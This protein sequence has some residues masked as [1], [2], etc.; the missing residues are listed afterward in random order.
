MKRLILYQAEGTIMAAAIDIALE[1]GRTEVSSK[2]QAPCRGLGPVAWALSWAG[3]MAGRYHNVQYS[4]PPQLTEGV[5]Q[6]RAQALLKVGKLGG[7]ELLEMQVL[8]MATTHL[9]HYS[10][11][12]WSLS[13]LL[14]AAEK[15][16]C[17]LS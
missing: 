13:S 9:G 15:L 16:P 8:D 10:T 11:D 6:D 7:A 17:F 5:L 2:V 12:F 4:L 1:D 3:H 14:Q